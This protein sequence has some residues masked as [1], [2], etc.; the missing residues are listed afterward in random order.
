MSNSFF[1]F[2]EFTIHQDKS[3]MK[4]CTD[5]C[6]LGAWTA[7]RIKNEKK[8]LDIGA[9]TGLLS[10]MLAQ[11]SEALI[12]AI[13]LD[14]DATA[15]AKENILQSPWFARVQI[16]EADIR[17]SAL[18]ADYDFIISNP[19]FY[20]SDLRSPEQK[21]NKAKHNETLGLDELMVAICNHLK[22]TGSFSILLPFFRHNYFEMLA[23]AHGFFAIEKLCVRQT[24]K[25]EPFRSIGLFSYQKPEKVIVQDLII[26]NEDGKY[27]P[28]FYGLMKDYYASMV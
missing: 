28:A 11:K 1:R 9:G 18:P 12:D 3:A 16:S 5:A 13:E 27:S 8:I 15:Q 14:S 23:A 19:P 7:V 25:H 6:L 17:R 4:V 10:L 2:K 21:K 20:E 24:P 26:K 22:K